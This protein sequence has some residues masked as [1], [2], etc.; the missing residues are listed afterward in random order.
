MKLSPEIVLKDVKMT[1][2]IDKSVTRGV[3]SLE[4][5]CDY[6]ISTRIAIEKTQGRRQTG[7]P[8]RVRIDIRIPDRPD[9]VVKHLSKVSKKIPDAISRQAEEAL[10]IET[11]SEASQPISRRPIPR[12]GRREEALPALIRRTFESARRELEKVVDRQR[13]EVKVHAQQQM[14]AVVEKIFREE[15]YGFL[16]ATDGQQIY[17]HRNSVLHNHWDR[18]TVGTTVRYTPEV[19]DNG[20]QASSVQLIDKPGVAEMHAQLH[21]LPDVS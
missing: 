4:R 6:I 17:L 2:L 7:N 3:A 10:Y 21:D 5:V 15:G 9:I 13:G 19:G 14:Q 8:Y 18:L 1:P 12:K 16:R 11:E 20:L